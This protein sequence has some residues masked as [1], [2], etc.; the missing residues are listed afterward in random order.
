M[1]IVNLRNQGIITLSEYTFPSG[2]I[3]LDVSNNSLV[4]L[5]GTPDGLDTLFV[6]NNPLV[7]LEGAASTIAKLDAKNCLL[8]TMAHA[9]SNLRDGVFINNNIIDTSDLL[10]CSQLGV[11]NLR[12]NNITTLSGFPES[13]KELNIENNKITHFDGT[14]PNIGRLNLRKNPF[15]NVGDIPKTVYLLDVSEIAD[16]DF[17]AIDFHRRMMVTKK[18]HTNKDLSGFESSQIA[19]LNIGLDEYNPRINEQYIDAVY[20]RVQLYMNPPVYDTFATY[21]NKWVIFDHSILMISAPNDFRM[22]GNA[23][24]YIG[25]ADCHVYC[26][27]NINIHGP[28]ADIFRVV[29]VKNEIRNEL[30]MFVTPCVIAS[31]KLSTSGSTVIQLT[32]IIRMTTKDTLAVYH[33]G[34][35]NT[36]M[37]LYNYQAAIYRM[38]LAY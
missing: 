37:T 19:E 8:T 36:T 17:N 15:N 18:K 24:E 33:R 6:N 35:A 28:E 25:D 30:P 27:L 20:N 26:N 34:L 13:I 21:N 29:V 14:M 12:N 10:N 5:I 32:K 11:I 2:I 7:S 38:N 22:K 9:P 31:S 3:G 23:M 1:A 4:N 16:P